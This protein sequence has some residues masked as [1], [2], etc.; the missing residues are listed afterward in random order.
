M[1]RFQ[2]FSQADSST[3]RKL[4]RHGTRPGDHRRLAELM[5]GRMWAEAAGG[6][7][8]TFHF[9]CARRLPN[10]RRRAAGTSSARSRKLQGAAADRRRQRHQPA[11]AFAAGRK[12]GMQV[13]ETEVAAE[14]LRWTEPARTSTWPSSTC[15]CRRWTGWSCA[16]MHAGRPAPW[17]LVLASSLAARGRVTPSAL[18]SAHLAKPVRQSQLFDTL[19]TRPRRHDAPREVAPR[20]GPP[21]PGSTTGPGGAPPAAASCWPRTSGQPEAGP[22]HPAAEATAP[23]WRATAWEAMSRSSETI[24]RGADGRADAGE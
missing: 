10:C 3:T 2:S 15:T 19:V 13:R 7:G 8:S 18:F 4:R 12:W 5:G 24:R 16:A 20:A 1:S 6:R 11:R 21:R 9:T 23:T 14:A 17:P 22:A